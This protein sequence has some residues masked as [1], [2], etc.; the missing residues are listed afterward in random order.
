D[1]HKDRTRVDG[2]QRRCKPCAILRVTK[3]FKKGSTEPVRAVEGL[4]WCPDC[5]KHRPVSRFGKRGDGL[6]T[7]CTEHQRARVAESQRR[8]SRELAH[9]RE[10]ERCHEVKPLRA[11]VVYRPGAR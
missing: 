6:Q 2:L 4:K 1:F 10:C 9:G 11:P 7:Y 8:R 3:G 5:G